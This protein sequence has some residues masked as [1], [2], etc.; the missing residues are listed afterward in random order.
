[1]KPSFAQFMRTRLATASLSCLLLAGCATLPPPT[2]ELA[3]AQQAVAQ[4]GDADADQYA[5]DL[6][7]SARVELSRAQAAMAAGDDDEARDIALAAAAAGDLARAQS[8]ARVLEQDLAQ[9]RGEIGTL[10]AQLQLP[11]DGETL[12]VVPPPPAD[13]DAM[14]PAMR[15]QALEA[16]PRFSGHA[17]YERLRAQ[18]AVARLEAA[19]RKQRPAAAVVAARRVA[20]AEVAARNELLA[21]AVDEAERS[22]SELLVEAS[23]REA[24]RARQEAERL[25]VQA[26]IQAE[27]TERLRATAAAET[28]ARQHAEEVILDVGGE[29]ARKLRAA[30]EREAELA[31]QEAELL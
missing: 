3:Q 11:P 25:R 12:V 20:A 21:A 2:Q 24:E 27:E 10:R 15:L 17:A 6:I 28:A 30:R 1:M 4:A 16:D 5:P 13:A 8:Q 29:Q 23:R 9:R 18:Q 26:Q 31:R 19:S 14:T 22:R 7:E